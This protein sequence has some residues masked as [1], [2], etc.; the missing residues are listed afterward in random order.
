MRTDPLRV[1]ALLTYLLSWLILAIAA[2]FHALPARRATTTPTISPRSLTGTVIQLCALLPIVLTLNDGPLRPHTLE[3]IATLL[4]AP[5]AVIFFL[6]AQRSALKHTDTLV[7]TGAYRWLRHPIYFAFG[8][9]LIATGC[10]VSAGPWL[11]AAIPIY[12]AG[13]EIRVRDEE[14][15]LTRRFAEQYATYRTRTRWRYLPGLR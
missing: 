14:A 2:I 1:A 11:C 9:M 13:T 10:I 7:T 12:I 6:W 3:S 5:L 8:L 4:G 15:E